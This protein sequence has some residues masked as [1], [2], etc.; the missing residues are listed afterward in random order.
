MS[1]VISGAE[2]RARGARDLHSALALV[3]GVAIS[4]GGDAGPTS[5][6]PSLWGLREIDAFLL[7][8]D[9]VPYGGAFNPAL[10]TLDLTNVE[11]IE[12]IR[13]PAPVSYGATRFVGIIHVIHAAAGVTAPTITLASGT[14]GERLAAY[15]GT[16]PGSTRF[17]HSVVLNGEQ[18][19]FTQHDAN[20]GRAHL[21]YRAAPDLEDDTL[22]AD[23]DFTHLRQDPYSPHPRDGMRLSKRFPRDANVNPRD[24]RQDQDRVQLTLRHAR[25]FGPRRFATTLSVAQT[26]SAATRGFLR[27]GFAS[28]GLTPNADGY[29]QH[30][31]LTDLWLDSAW[32]GRLGTQLQWQASGFHMD[33]RNLVIRENVGG[34]PALAN[35]GRE[36]LRGGELELSWRWT[37]SLQLRGSGAYHDSRFVDYARLRNDGSLQQLEGRA[38]ELSPQVQ[39]ALALLLAPAQG[40]IA[41][42]VAQYSGRRYLNKANTAVAPGYASLDAGLGYRWPHFE[43]RV[44]GSNL[45]NRHDAVAESEIGDAQFYRLSGRRLM[46]TATWEL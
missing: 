44:D 46:A 38:L 26:A 35:A 30:Q 6:V 22:Q 13:G 15:A 18:R 34:R 10:A 28:D 41:S 37:A 8:V 14:R 20:A 43:L 29:R 7:V 16:L 1:S 19:S 40:V 9:G 39:G 42:L 5:S 21:L 31:H 27:E 25:D 33:F 23:L 2:L 32:S 45:A 4:P 36:R 24:G 12:V 11:R 17:R 3:A